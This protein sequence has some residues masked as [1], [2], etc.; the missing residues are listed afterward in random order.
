MCIKKHILGMNIA[1]WHS[2]CLV[3]AD[4]WVPLSVYTHT[5]IYTHVCTCIHTQV[6]MHHQCTHKY[7]HTHMY[8]HTHTKRSIQFT[9]LDCRTGWRLIYL[10]IH[11]PLHFKTSPSSLFLPPTQ[12]PFPGISYS[13]SIL[14]RPVIL[15]STSPG[16]RREKPEPGNHNAE[17]IAPRGILG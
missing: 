5:C 16:K 11:F 6:H 17:K 4:S 12:Y 9:N 13:Q 7:M 1:Q 14:W 15:T 3:C 8:M 10:F 2:T